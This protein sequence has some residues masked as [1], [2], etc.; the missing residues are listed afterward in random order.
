MLSKQELLSYVR[1]TYQ[2]YK[3]HQEQFDDTLENF[4]ERRCKCESQDDKRQSNRIYTNSL[5]K[6]Y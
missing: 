1:E 3:E 4:I 5:R 6:L 2:E